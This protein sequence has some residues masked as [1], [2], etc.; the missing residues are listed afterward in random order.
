MGRNKR[1]QLVVDKSFQLRFVGSFLLS[2]MGALI[3]FTLLVGLYYW[4]SNMAGE[5]L[6]REFITIDRQ[7]IEER[8]ITEEGVERVVKVPTTKTILG[9]KRWELILPAI[10]VNNLIIMIL[11]TV[12][13]I[14]YSH[15]IAGPVYRIN[16]ELDKVLQGK[17]GVKIK[18]REKD[19]LRGIAIRVNQLIQRLDQAE[20]GQA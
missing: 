14:R 6:F 18:L 13:G 15:R 9:V 1:K 20:E 4:V 12:F 5:N 7:V 2:V 19:R 17:K 3:I 11:L 10:L 8:T 16:C